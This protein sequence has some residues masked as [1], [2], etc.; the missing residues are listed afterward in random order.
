MV[1]P[2]AVKG[3]AIFLALAE[4]MPDVQFAAVPTWGATSDDLAALR[5]L[6]NVTLVPASDDI[7]EILRITRVLLVP[8]VWAEARSRIVLEAMERGVPVIAGISVAF[9]EAKLGVP[10][11]LPVNPIKRYL[12][13]VDENMVPVADVPPQDVV[14]GSRRL[15]AWLPIARI[16]M[17]FPE[18]RRAALEYGDRATVWPFEAFLSSL[19]GKPKKRVEAAEVETSAL[20]RLS[21]DKRKLLAIRLKNAPLVRVMSGSLES[22]RAR[23]GRC[24]CFASRTRAVE[25]RPIPHGGVP[26]RVWSHALSGCPAANREW[27][28]RPSKTWPPW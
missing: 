2:C 17:R 1:N 10:Y 7:D 5:R 6:P 11:I 12:P 22:K 4:K 20:D 24:G 16:G 28:S 19:T 27:R 15:A 9:P 26:S 18:S 21:P 14:R 3:I 25:R 23:Q 8:S 13:A